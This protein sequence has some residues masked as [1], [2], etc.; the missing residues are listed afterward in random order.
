MSPTSPREQAPGLTRG[1][2]PRSALRRSRGTHLAPHKRLEPAAL[3]SR[4]ERRRRAA[5]SAP[6]EESGPGPSP[7]PASSPPRRRREVKW[8]RDGPPRLSRPSGRA[9]QRW[10]RPRA[11]GARRHL[12]LPASAR[13]AQAPPARPRPPPAVGASARRDRE[14]PGPALRARGA[15]ATARRGWN[16]PPPASWKPLLARAGRQAWCQSR[17]CRRRHRRRRQARWGKAAAREPAGAPRLRRS[18]SGDAAPP[19]RPPPPLWPGRRLCEV[20]PSGHTEVCPEPLARAC[21]QAR[22]A[23]HD[24]S[25]RPVL[26]LAC[27]ASPPGARHRRRRTPVTPL[28]AGHLAAREHLRPSRATY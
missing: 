18:R 1:A 10:P 25:R 23:R 19:H 14:G 28:P 15:A 9:A 8:G 27:A 3:A 22:R 7:T 24:R 6:G 16:A 5:P 2:E 20:R 12:H 17:D 4:A 21:A 11:E 13:R 26:L